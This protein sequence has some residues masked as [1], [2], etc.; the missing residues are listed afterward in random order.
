MFRTAFICLAD[1]SQLYS[2][3][4]LAHADRSWLMYA[5][6][7]ARSRKMERAMRSRCQELDAQAAR[8]RA[9]P[10]V[11]WDPMTRWCAMA[12]HLRRPRGFKDEGHMRELRRGTPTQL[13]LEL[14][15]MRFYPRR[16]SPSTEGVSRRPVSLAPLDLPSHRT[17]DA[18]SH[19]PLG[20]PAGPRADKQADTRGAKKAAMGPDSPCGV[21]DLKLEAPPLEEL[22]SS[23]IARSCRLRR[24][25]VLLT[26]ALET[27]PPAEE[28]IRQGVLPKSPTAL[29]RRPKRPERPQRQPKRPRDESTGMAGGSHRDCAS[30]HTICRQAARSTDHSSRSVSMRHPRATSDN[31]ARARLPRAALAAAAPSPREG[32]DAYLRARR[33]W[34]PA[35]MRRLGA[36]GEYDAIPAPAGVNGQRWYESAA[37]RSARA[38]NVQLPSRPYYWQHTRA[39]GTSP[40]GA[41]LDAMESGL[42]NTAC[43]A[44]KVH[45]I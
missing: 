36:S 31:G 23:F 2:S 41:T 44:P 38:P 30:D 4:P 9:D 39:G 20:S 15:L 18:Q 25:T 19:T 24:A 37:R 12:R 28:L 3:V 10:S 6:S 26:I 17:A 5:A 27:R 43:V 32:Q 34:S 22:P 42:L 33:S 40:T 8:A 35:R 14:T 16:T 21:A 29:L 45:P 11:S 1:N 7:F 13:S